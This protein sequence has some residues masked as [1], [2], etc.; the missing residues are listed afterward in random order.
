MYVL[1]L[2]HS[3]SPSQSYCCHG[4]WYGSVGFLWQ[5]PVRRRSD[6]RAF[7]ATRHPT[8]IWDTLRCQHTHTLQLVWCDD[9]ARVREG[10]WSSGCCYL[11]YSF[12]GKLD[13]RVLRKL[14]NLLS[15]FLSIVVGPESFVSVIDRDSKRH[16]RD[17][18]RKRESKKNS[19]PELSF[20]SSI[21]LIVNPLCV[22]SIRAASIHS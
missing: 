10:N 19:M 5:E 21:L 6:G 16:L 11:F 20:F 1:P 9:I 22:L 12:I 8:V 7:A 15:F 4:Y 2:T 3:L 18:N 13:F 17:K 14:R